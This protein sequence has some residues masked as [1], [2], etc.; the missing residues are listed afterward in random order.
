MIHIKMGVQSVPE[1]YVIGI[2]SQ[3]TEFE[4]KKGTMNQPLSLTFRATF[5][6]PI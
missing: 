3:W 1:T 5:V 2:L 4:L 6:S